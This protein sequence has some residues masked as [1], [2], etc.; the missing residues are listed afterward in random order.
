MIRSSD[1][2]AE[3]QSRIHKLFYYSVKIISYF[4]NIAKTC[5]PPLMLS[6]SSIV[7]V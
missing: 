2:G 6:S 5:L 4:K 7:Y 1:V 3:Y